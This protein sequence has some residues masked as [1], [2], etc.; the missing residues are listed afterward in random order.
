MINPTISLTDM[1]LLRLSDEYKAHM[2][3]R[4]AANFCENAG[5]TKAAAYFSEEAESE[6]KHAGKIQQFLNDWGTKFTMP[7]VGMLQ[8]YTSLPEWLRQAYDIEAELY[9]QYNNN[10]GE[11]FAADKSAFNLLM[12]FVDIQYKSVAEYRTLLDKLILYNSDATG[13]K[14]F[15][16]E[17]F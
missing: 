12:G 10:A 9:K 17:A 5:Y 8:T 13:I 15:E 7:N 6:L 16:Q 2:F 14:L 3:Y 11:A 4:N 1:L